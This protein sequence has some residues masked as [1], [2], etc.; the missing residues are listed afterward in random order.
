MP[1][2]VE[3]VRAACAV[4]YKY[5]SVSSMAWGVF[6]WSKLRFEVDGNRVTII[7]ALEQSGLRW[8]VWELLGKDPKM[9]VVCIHG[10]R[11]DLI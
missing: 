8:Y 2:T 3:Q 1:V 5:R 11:P 7:G 6:D 4:A 10:D 9:E